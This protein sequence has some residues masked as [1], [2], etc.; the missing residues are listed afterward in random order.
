M[1][2]ATFER[3]ADGGLGRGYFLRRRREVVASALREIE[4]A[5]SRTPTRDLAR[6][7]IVRQFGRLSSCA[8]V[9]VDSAGDSWLSTEEQLVKQRG[10][11]RGATSRRAP[12][13]VAIDRSRVRRI[14][15]SV[16]MATSSCP[17][18]VSAP[19][20]AVIGAASRAIVA[21]R[22]APTG[23]KRRVASTIVPRASADA[24]PVPA[25]DIPDT[26]DE[27]EAVSPVDFAADVSAALA[28]DKVVILGK[29]GALR[30]PGFVASLPESLR[31]VWLEA[32]AA[33]QA[34]DNG[35][36]RS[37]MVPWDN[38]GR[39]KD[40]VV[41]VLPTAVSRHNC[42]AAAFAVD[43]LL[44]GVHPPRTGKPSA[45]SP[46]LPPPPT[47]FPSPSPSPGTSRRT[48]RRA[49]G[50]AAA[51]ESSG[52]RVALRGRVLVAQ[53]DCCASPLSC[54]LDAETSRARRRG[55]QGGASRVS[56][57]GHPARGDGPR[58]ARR[59]G[60]GGCGGVGGKSRA[61]RRVG[62]RCGTTL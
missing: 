50:A 4:T 60:G 11:Q 9:A 22:V 30:S 10:R 23:A 56:R 41:G 6:Q 25:V 36:K 16:A 58:R 12:L 13:S 48:P 47:R 2:V 59:R 29:R 39:L 52:A 20:A 46:P 62:T 26:N 55:R 1:A 40:V 57:R 35:G 15:A 53:V 8:A 32:V 54:D 24:P 17:A 34:G 44:A 28:A 5:L 19:R 14:R 45:S 33:V 7:S 31:T 42:P 61:G 37:I 21:R 43:A 38:G 27:W 51:A 18:F 49:C 3:L